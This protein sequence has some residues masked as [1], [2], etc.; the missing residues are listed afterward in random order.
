MRLLQMKPYRSELSRD[1][2]NVDVT[3]NSGQAFLWD[4][5]GKV[6]YGVDG[7]NILKCNDT[8]VVKSYKHDGGD[9]FRC[10]DD[11]TSITQVISKDA[12]VKKAVEQ[13]PGLRI[14]RQDPFQCCI[15]FISSSNASIQKNRSCL[16][17]LC[18]ELG[19]SVSFDGMQFHLFPEAYRIADAPIDRISKCGFGY[20]SK[21]VKQAS[22]IVADGQ[23]SWNAVRR[24]DYYR[25]KE[26]LLAIPGIGNKVADCI[27]LFSLDKLEAFPLDRWVIKILQEYYPNRFSIDTRQITDRQYNVLHGEIAEYF[28]EYAGYTQQ[29][30]FKMERENMKKRW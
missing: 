5:R 10:K 24:R 25:A 2:V 1:T 9:F 4:R 18:R 27:L 17:A 14:I 16:K 6:W 3:I 13:Y 23:M 8:G 21:Y 29:F 26:S 22:K 30:L 19:E 7:Q 15:S 28:G 12:V 20:R 11:Y